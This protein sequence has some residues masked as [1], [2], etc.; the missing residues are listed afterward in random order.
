MLLFF[1]FRALEVTKKTHT[2]FFR[3]PNFLARWI[4][5][6]TAFAIAHQIFPHAF[7]AKF[8]VKC[9]VWRKKNNNQ[10]L[11]VSK[12]LKN[13][14]LFFFSP[15]IDCRSIHFSQL[16]LVKTIFCKMLI[17]VLYSLVNTMIVFQFAE[18]KKFR[19]LYVILLFYLPYWFVPNIHIFKTIYVLSFFLDW[20]KTFRIFY[21]LLYYLSFFF[22]PVAH[23]LK[24]GQ[25]IN[26]HILF[27]AH[28][29]YFF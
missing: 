19:I 7:F 22:V 23:F 3:A 5:H 17:L 15:N 12:S 21:I 1:F 24:Y 16:I 8:F 10:M 27:F 6:C 25:Y 28:H 11:R 26:C 13:K 29:L 18:K 2:K 14:K 9:E 20:N 4:F